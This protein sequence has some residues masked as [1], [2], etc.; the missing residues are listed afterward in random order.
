MFFSYLLVIPFQCDNP[1]AL[2]IIAIHVSTNYQIKSFLF[3]G[4]SFMNNFSIIFVVGDH[5][6]M[7]VGKFETNF[8]PICVL[9]A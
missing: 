2:I 5:Y 8:E 1:N 9:N 3:L 4:L 6:V 7:D